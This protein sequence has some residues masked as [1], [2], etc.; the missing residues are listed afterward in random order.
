MLR[1]AVHSIDP[2][3][4]KLFPSQAVPKRSGIPLFRNAARQVTVTTACRR[5]GET[6]G[7]YRL[8]SN[9][10]SDMG[11]PFNMSEIANLPIEESLHY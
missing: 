1:L 11:I 6:V 3:I 8:A 10:L 5:I 4:E 9:G 2:I 7:D